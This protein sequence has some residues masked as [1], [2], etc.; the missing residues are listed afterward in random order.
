MIPLPVVAVGGG[1]G[2][3]HR[4]VQAAKDTLLANL[5]VDVAEKFGC[6]SESIGLSTGRLDVF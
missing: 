2:K 6:P 3:G 5:W 4:H 1:A